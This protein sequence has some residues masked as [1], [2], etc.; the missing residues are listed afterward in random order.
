MLYQGYVVRNI[1]PKLYRNPY[2]G[3]NAFR[4]QIEQI[5]AELEE[6]NAQ[7]SRLRENSIMYDE[8]IKLE[9]D[10]NPELIQ[11]YMNAPAD[12]TRETKSLAEIKAE[13]KE[14]KKD[15][16]LLELE[17]KKQAIEKEHESINSALE[18]FREK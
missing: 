10:V 6:K 5:K 18:K 3:Q 9:A 14:A 17:I 7:R 13:L 4:M 1:D 15:P 16:S 11:L 12:L 2:I 8:I